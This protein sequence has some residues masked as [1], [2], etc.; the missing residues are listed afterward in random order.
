M[1]D[2]WGKH[3]FLNDTATTTTNNNTTSSSNNN[4]KNLATI[5]VFRSICVLSFGFALPNKLQATKN[6]SHSM[7]PRQLADCLV[8]GLRADQALESKDLNHLVC[9]GNAPKSF[10]SSGPSEDER[11]FFCI[12]FPVVRQGASQRHTG[13]RPNRSRIFPPHLAPRLAIP[14]ITSG[15]DQR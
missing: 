11:T 6:S 14:A 4:I 7:P 1:K 13:R 10:S 3:Q 15:V 8:G 12:N 9:G 2:L 5:E